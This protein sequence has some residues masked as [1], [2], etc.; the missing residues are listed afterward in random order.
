MLSKKTQKNLW[1][2]VTIIV[3]LSMILTLVL[4]FNFSYY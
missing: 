4:Q 1:I 3:S 2:V